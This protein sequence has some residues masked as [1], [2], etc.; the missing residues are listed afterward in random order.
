MTFYFLKLQSTNRIPVILCVPLYLL[1]FCCTG[2]E[3]AEL[4]PPCIY[5]QTKVGQP[6][7]CDWNVSPTALICLIDF[8]AEKSSIQTQM[9]RK[10]RKVFSFS[11]DANLTLTLFMVRCGETQMCCCVASLSQQGS[12]SAYNFI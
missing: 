9:N 2:F 12:D 7:C 1:L 11:A 3:V 8:N 4:S 10:N 5:R 6:A